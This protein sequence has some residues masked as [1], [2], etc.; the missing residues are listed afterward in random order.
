MTVAEAAALGPAATFHGFAFF[1]IYVI[2]LL[3]Y[4]INFILFFSP[5]IEFEVVQR[6]VFKSLLQV[7]LVWKSSWGILHT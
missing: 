4:R 3:L 5:S 7:K 6:I 1:N 2:L